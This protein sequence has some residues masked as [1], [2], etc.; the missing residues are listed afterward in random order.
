MATSPVTTLAAWHPGLDPQDCNEPALWR[1]FMAPSSPTLRRLL[2]EAEAISVG[3]DNTLSAYSRL[4]DVFAPI[5]AAAPVGELD[6][7]ALEA[8]ERL[9]FALFRLV[10]VAGRPTPFSTGLRAAIRNPRIAVATPPDEHSPD[11]VARICL[12]L[13]TLHEA[14]A[15]GELM[16]LEEADLVLT[17]VIEARPALAAD[18]AVAAS[19][20]WL[21][22]RLGAHS[23]A[24][25]S[26]WK[27]AEWI[28]NRRELPRVASPTLVA[29]DSDFA[30]RDTARAAIRQHAGALLAEFIDAALDTFLTAG[31]TADFAARPTVVAVLD[32]TPEQLGAA[33]ITLDRIGTVA[34]TD[35][36]DWGW[37]ARH[38]GTYE[39]EPYSW[40][41]ERGALER[42]AALILRRRIVVADTD[43]ASLVTR[44][45]R[46]H[47]YRSRHFLNQALRLARQAP[48]GPTAQALA[49]L[50]SDRE[51]WMPEDWAKDIGALAER[52]PP[53]ATLA[54]PLIDHE[55][56]RAEEALAAHF[57]N[58]LDHRLHDAAHR[59][60]L[61]RMGALGEADVQAAAH[62]QYP[63]RGTEYATLL[64]EAGPDSERDDTRLSGVSR[65]VQLQDDVGQRRINGGLKQ[66]AASIAA[67]L[68]ALAPI[69]ARHG[70]AAARLGILAAIPQARSTPSPKFLAAADAAASVL[71]APERL[72][73][74]TGLLAGAAHGRMGARPL[75]RGMIF[76]ARDGNAA[77][78]G[79]ILADFALRHCYQTDSGSGIRDEKL[80]NACLWTL[81]HMNGGAGVPF[82]ARMLARVKYPKIRARIDAALNDAAAASGLSRGELD[83]L[84]VPAHLLGEDG[85]MR[86][87]VGGGSA[88]LTVTGRRLDLAWQSESGKTIKS[89]TAAMKADKPGLQAAKTLAKE[90]EADLATQAARLQRLYLEDRDWPA[91]IWRQRYLEHPLLRVLARGLIWTVEGP[92]G[93]ASALPADGTLRDAAGA[94]VDAEGAR[95][96]LWHPIDDSPE[97]AATWRARIAAL[98][99]VQPF[100]QAWREIYR[101]TEAERATATYSNRWAGHILK[102]HQFITLARLNGWTVTH[103]MNV[104]APNDAPAHLLLPAHRLVADYWVAGA[105]EGPDAEMLGSGAFTY[106]ETDRLMFS[107]VRDEKD[108][109]YGPERGLAVAVEAV[110]AIVLSEV[111]RHCDLFTAVASIAADPAWRD[112]GQDAAHPNQWQRAATEYWERQS[113][114]ELT[115]AARTRRALLETIVPRLAIAERCSFD[116]RALIVRG[117]LHSYRIHIGSAAIAVLPQLRHLC[118]VPA[119]SGEWENG[120]IYL[121]FAGDRTLSVILSKAILLAADDRITDPVILRQL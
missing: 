82:L 6:T 105:G 88:V 95:I 4:N 81:I 23:H 11:S 2:A 100:V 36:P 68:T 54:P 62:R 80:G 120:P 97:M 1:D 19:L 101:V 50:P 70:D 60:L 64:R 59:D 46:N 48:D 61:A 22:A 92:R 110:P 35:Y 109:A 25:R 121:P 39:P 47:A 12:A 20:D 83:E 58:P 87:P 103:R 42:V 98:R 40:D 69:V 56:Y 67:Q 37:L 86:M 33:L 77:T 16:R 76:L 94:P 34:F 13:G 44:L 89:P 78:V 116:E 55:H 91:A 90:I 96:R 38:G 28:V 14:V 99:V 102:Q 9:P 107:R 43:M 31:A 24:M 51:A 3:Y 57:A 112:R 75:V 84:S 108:S 114:A 21:L 63:P 45:G 119:A 29:I 65:T 53:R 93:R 85:G 115:E 30:R 7:I 71:A 49:R 10:N 17:R 52:G 18:P 8:L 111:M 41:G 26:R 117:K 118:I 72:A 79:P 104:D 73:L 5:L 32:Q 27:L 66:M 113:F 106:V 15:T 74:L